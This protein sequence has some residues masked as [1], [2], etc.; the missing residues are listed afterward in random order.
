MARWGAGAFGSPPPPGTRR[1]DS[2][3]NIIAQPRIAAALLLPGA[4]AVAVLTGIASPTSDE[5]A[6]APFT[7]QGKTPLLV[8]AVQG[9]AITL[10]PS[11]ALARARLWPAAAA[12]ADI[13]P[14]KMFAEHLRLNKDK[15]LG[16]RIASAAVSIPGL[17]QKALDKD[18]KDNLY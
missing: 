17:M 8:T 15:G 12:P 5:A 6:R 13:K 4:S 18:Y 2:F 3:R 14:A 11:A 9:L 10:R 16:A 1:T 7:V